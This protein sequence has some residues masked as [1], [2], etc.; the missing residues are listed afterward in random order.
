MNLLSAHMSMPRRVTPDSTGSGRPP[1]PRSTTCTSRSGSKSP[2]RSCCLR[3]RGWCSEAEESFWWDWENFWH[4]VWAVGRIASQKPFLKLG[5]FHQ[6]LNQGFAT[7]SGLTETRLANL[8]CKMHMNDGIRCRYTILST[9][10]SFHGV[11]CN[12]WGKNIDHI[13]QEIYSVPF[14]RFCA[15]TTCCWPYFFVLSATPSISPSTLLPCLCRENSPSMEKRQKPWPPPFLPST[16]NGFN[17]N[18]PCTCLRGQST[19]PQ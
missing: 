5:L 15:L 1:R 11:S 6:L 10:P 13:K 4:I 2:T 14:T 8:E 3:P 19:F 9:R 18:G 16:T 12:K 17:P 7:H